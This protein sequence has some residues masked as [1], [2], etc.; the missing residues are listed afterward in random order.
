M[1]MEIG[2]IK[3]ETPFGASVKEIDFKGFNEL[4]A[5]VEAPL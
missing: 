2:M 3:K 4:L 5:E 1:D